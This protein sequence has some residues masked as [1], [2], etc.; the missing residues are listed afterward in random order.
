M[1]YSLDLSYEDALGVMKESG[2]ERI[3]AGMLL[4]YQMKK[5]VFKNQ[6]M[7]DVVNADNSPYA[8]LVNMRKQTLI[9]CIRMKTGIILYLLEDDTRGAFDKVPNPLYNTQLNVQDRTS[10]SNFTNNFSIDWYITEALRLKGNIAIHHQKSEGVVFKP[11]KHTDFSNMMGDNYYRRG[12][13]QT[14]EGKEFGYDA[15]MI[16]SFFKRI[17]D[18]VLN[19]NAALN[20]QDL[21]KEEYTVKVEGFPDENLD[22]IVFGASYPKSSTPTEKMKFHD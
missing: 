6:M 16:L 5:I 15:S 19:V 8:V 20:M 2:R 21:S 18:H 3:S 9:M 12:S 1:R 13:Y 14:T 22:Y 17:H 10:Y 7:Y 11:A 4:Q